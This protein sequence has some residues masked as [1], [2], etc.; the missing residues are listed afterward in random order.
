MGWDIRK[1]K[2]FLPSS[3]IE[4]K[5]KISL[6][7]WQQYVDSDPE[8]MWAEESPIAE[9][10]KKAGHEW[11]KKENYR[12]QAYY[13][14]NVKKNWP[15]LRFS[16]FL[17]TISVDTERQTL[18]RVEKMWEV[19]KYFNA[20]LFKNGIRFTEKKLEKLREKYTKKI[21]EKET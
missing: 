18:K 14:F 19:T 1:G 13:D 21:K 12:H 17:G 9:S 15:G 5:D 7:E 2:K 4:D 8:L 20:Y 11:I 3:L 10:F 16:Y 6:L